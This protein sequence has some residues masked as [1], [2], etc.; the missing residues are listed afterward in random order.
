[1]ESLQQFVVDTVNRADQNREEDQLPAGQIPGQSVTDKQRKKQVFGDMNPFHRE[2]G[3]RQDQP[4]QNQEQA[5]KQPVAPQ[6]ISAAATDNQE[7]QD[8]REQQWS[9]ENEAAAEILVDQAK[10]G[11]EVDIEDNQQA[12]EEIESR[13]EKRG[14]VPGD[15]LHDFFTVGAFCKTQIFVQNQ[16]IREILP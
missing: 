10:E 16:G 9:C 6:A 11:E 12:T 4:E 15:I 5:D 2:S 7:Q 3:I 13:N 8:K 14:F 1:M